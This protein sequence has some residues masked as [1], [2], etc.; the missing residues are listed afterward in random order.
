MKEHL[1][2]QYKDLLKTTKFDGRV[3][4]LVNP[5][6]QTK[7]G[8]PHS[9]GESTGGR[10]GDSTGRSYVFGGSTVEVVSGD[11]TTLHVDA[12]VNAANER[13]DHIGGLAKA[14][15]DAGIVMNVVCI[16]LKIIEE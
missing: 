4:V 12:I 11:L 2:S 8:V 16:I 15:A 3:T 13:L 14:I 5:V 7:G 6:T 1:L 10:S 9:Q